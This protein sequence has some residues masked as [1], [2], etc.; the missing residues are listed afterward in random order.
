MVDHYEIRRLSPS[1]SFFFARLGV[2]LGSS[3]GCR[4]PIKDFISRDSTLSLVL[5]DLYPLLYQSLNWFQ[6]LREM[7]VEERVGSEIRSSEVETGLSSSDD[8]IG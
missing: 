4:P 5:A 8:T 6:S 3:S 2:F 1:V 7:F